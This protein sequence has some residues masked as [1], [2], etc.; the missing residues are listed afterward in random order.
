MILALT[1]STDVITL[2]LTHENQIKSKLKTVNS[3]GT[4]P[5]TNLMTQKSQ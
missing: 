3:D 1:T 2:L 5:S 4:S